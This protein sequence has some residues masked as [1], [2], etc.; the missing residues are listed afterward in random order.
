[1]LTA[2]CQNC[3]AAKDPKDYANPNCATC[4]STAS[5]AAQHYAAEHPG[6]AQSDALYA[7]RKALL[8]RA[9]H[10]HRN[11]VDPRAFGATRG[12]I[13]IPPQG[14]DRGGPA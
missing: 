10:A 2:T 1:M 7:G 12:M 13:P 3:G 5:E 11:F 6:C 9:H 8:Q 4:T 14:G